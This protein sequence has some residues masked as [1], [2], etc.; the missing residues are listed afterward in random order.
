MIPYIHIAYFKSTENYCRCTIMVK[1]NDKVQFIERKH[2]EKPSEQLKQFNEELDTSNDESYKENVLKETLKEKEFLADILEH[3]SQPFA[4]GYPDGRLGLFNHAFELLTG[5]TAEELHTL[6]W[7]TV[8]TPSKWREMEK[9]K[10]DELN[11]TGVP[12]RYEKEYTRKDGSRVPI[13]LL[14]NRTIDRDGNLE[15]YHSFITD[16]T[17]RRKSEEILKRQAA[18]LDVSYEAIFSWEFDGSILSWNQGAEKLYGF[19]KD[20]AVGNVSH[21]LLKT[22]FP[23]DFKEFTDILMKNKMWTGELTHTTKDG[24]II[25][26]E[27]HQQLIQDRSNKNIVI[28]TNRDITKRKK[29]ENALKISQQRIS[30]IIESINDYIYSVDRNWN[31]IYVN[32]SSAKDVGYKSSELVDKNIWKAVP[33]LVGTRIEEEF[34]LAMDKRE[35]RQFEWK[36]IYTDSYREFNVYPSVEGITVYGKDITK[37]KKAE[38]EIENE[39]KRLETILETTPSAV[40]IIDAPNGNISYINKRAKEL[41]GVNI[42]GLD[43]VEAIAKVKSKRIDGTEYP[44]GEGPSARALKGQLVRNEEIMLE[45]PDGTVIPI[46]CSAAPILNLEGKIIAAVA[47]FD[48]ITE[49]KKEEKRKQELLENE[50]ELREEITTA[51]EEL[52]FTTRKL[53]NSND[54]LIQAQIRQEELINKLQTSNK[55]LEQFAYVA[56][57]DLQEPLRMVTSFTQL[58][59]RRYKGQLDKNAD[60]YIGFVVEGAQRMKELIDD[61]LTFSRLKTVNKYEEISLEDLLNDITFT[62]KS[63]I[64]KYNAKITHDHLPK[65][66]GDPLQIGQLFQN[67]ISNAIKFN[68]N[69]PPEIHISSNTSGNVWVFGVSDNG[70]GIDPKYH[71]QIFNI[72]KRLHTRKDY[73]GTGIGLAICKRIVEKHGGRIWVESEE[74]KGSTFYFTIPK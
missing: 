17:E 6:D 55:E 66:L 5:Y 42:T 69:E 73:D 72:F 68:D 22:E 33:R 45:Q 44:I 58:L 63:S 74:G 53:Q 52:Q 7:S 19:S 21:E 56:S 26:I 50:Q 9:E 57:H 49:Q 4:I 38:K 13:E 47:I 34:R 3:S 11:R 61:L 10:L 15:Y 29:A 18:L 41:Y 36:T 25:I 1:D 37:R 51:N 64:E 39:N 16:I 67:L 35:I 31:F 27:S 40:I 46:L 12:I 28:E 59:E 65:I 62:L 48:D 24:Q 60:D 54:N 32:E 30:D 2:K 14:V 43:L 71:E 20:E 8:L 23:I 70:I